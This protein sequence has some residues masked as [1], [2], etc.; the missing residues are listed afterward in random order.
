MLT[1]RAFGAALLGVAAAAATAATA[2]LPGRPHAGAPQ[3]RRHRVEI[4]AFAFMPAQLAIAAGDT[5]EWVN[6]DI[7][8]HTATD[9]AEAWDTGPL[10]K[11][12]TATVTFST[13]GR[14]AYFCRFHPHMRAEIVAA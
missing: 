7:A 8:P 9:T 10:Q 3:P 1:R 5:V 11:A 6:R 12:E 14:Y 2:G 13:P 4:A